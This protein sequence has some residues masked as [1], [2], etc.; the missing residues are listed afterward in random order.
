METFALE[1]L[2]L[3]L[4]WIHVIAATL[5]IG[6]SFLFMWMDRS[7]VAPRAGRE[8]T[9]VG[10]LWMVHSGGFYEVIKR[11]SLSRDEL[12][13]ALHWF[14]WEAYTTWW[15][16]FL[17]LGV[18]YYLSNGAYLVESPS[19]RFS[20]GWAIAASLGLLAAGWIV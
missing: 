19:S 20:A 5:W 6:D 9:V 14:K 10:E 3:L 15:S 16:G 18:V 7:L 11:R 13:S 1:W 4:R 12:P 17:L 2:N 8:G